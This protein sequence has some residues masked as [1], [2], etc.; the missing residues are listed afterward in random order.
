MTIP[1]SDPG[2][3]KTWGVPVV[4]GWDNLPWRFLALFSLKPLLKY[5]QGYQGCQKNWKNLRLFTLVP[6]CTNIQPKVKKLQNIFKINKNHQIWFFGIFQI[7]CNFSWKLAQKPTKVWTLSSF[8]FFWYPWHP[9]GWLIS[10]DTWVLNISLQWRN[11]A[12]IFSF[13]KM[14]FHVSF[15]ILVLKIVRLKNK[16]GD[17]W[18]L[19]SPVYKSIP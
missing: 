1:Y 8:Q 9:W 12:E 3:W 15:I 14:I 17:F 18:F 7:L 10:G 13:I 5:P 16:K 19:K 2:R 6:F 11:L 4:I